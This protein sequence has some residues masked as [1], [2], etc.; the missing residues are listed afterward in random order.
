V[1]WENFRSFEDTGWLRIRPLT[2]LIGPNN[3]GKTAV[4]APLLLL[5]QT[6]LSRDSGLGFRTNGDLVN[7]GSFRDLVFGHEKDR[8]LALS[9]RFHTH[10]PRANIKPVGAYPPGEAHF[11][12]AAD[13]QD[14]ARTDLKKYE[15]FDIYGRR[16]LARVRLKSGRYSLLALPPGLPGRATRT[17]RRDTR[18]DRV[19]RERI[20]RDLPRNFLFSATDVLNSVV[21]A[22]REDAARTKPLD[23]EIPESAAMYLRV[24]AAVRGEM[25]EV[26][27]GVS[28]VGPLRERPLRLYQLSGELPPDVGI[29]GQFAPEILYR[30]RAGELPGL[31]NDWLQRF[32]LAHSLRCAEV[33]TD[34]FSVLLRRTQR[35]P[36]VNL[37][38]TGFGVSQILPLIVEGLYGEGHTLTIAE[39]PEIHL[40]PR[41][42][43][44]L[45]DLFAAI[46]AEGRSVLVET[47]SEHLVLRLRRLVAEGDIPASDIAL[48]Y[49]EKTRD[50]ST[51]RDVQ[52][53]SNGHIEPTDWPAGF[54]E[55]ALHEAMGLAAAQLRQH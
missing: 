31:V 24:V 38:D 28:Y 26:L 42:Q 4:L 37:A 18:L 47:H 21:E 14:P 16:Y 5:K 20:G 25:R 30:E 23:I 39:Q 52:L 8:S 29:R 13:P 46:V 22:T 10:R 53:K 35:S 27:D 11:T 15:V 1:R 43:T 9:V 40:N 19:F 17:R 6:L 51:I 33:G 48:Y 54:F 44:R 34:A 2:V 49:V 3:S 32:D 7:A 41:L 36:E 45:A 50:R 12:F 55:D